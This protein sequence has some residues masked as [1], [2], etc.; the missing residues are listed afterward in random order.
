MQTQFSKLEVGA[1][2]FTEVPE[3]LFGDSN[4][5][6]LIPLRETLKTSFNVHKIFV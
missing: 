2:G 6:R 5:F 1:C 4:S 3:F